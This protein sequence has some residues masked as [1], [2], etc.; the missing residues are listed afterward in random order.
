MGHRGRELADPRRGPARPVGAMYRRIL[1]P[2]DFSE[3]SAH[4]LEHAL[5]LARLTDAEIVLFHAFDRPSIAR[6]PASDAALRK[7]LDGAYREA[8]DHLQEIAA[9]SQEVRCRPICSEG[10]PW[11]EIVAVAERERCDLICMSSH[12]R[13][14][15]ADVLLGGVTEK[16]M[17]RAGCPVLVLR[18]GPAVKLP[19]E[20]EVD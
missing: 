14:A 10:R 3:H 8:C 1:V 19:D 18:S 11:S 12:G 6:L 4:A 15:L 7:Y 5:G 2:T 13:S 16:V 20:D 9:S 17:H